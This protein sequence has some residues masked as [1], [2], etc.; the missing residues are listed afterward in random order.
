MTSLYDRL[1]ILTRK[2]I[3]Y[4]LL[5]FIPAILPP[6]TAKGLWYLL[7]VTNFSFYVSYALFDYKATYS[8]LMPAFHGLMLLA[9]LC[10]VI[11][12]KRVS[13]LF[14]IF[15]V[16][17]FAFSV[18]TQTMVHTDTYGLVILTEIFV[19]YSIVIALWIWEIIVQKNDLSFKDGMRPW[20]LLP[21]AVVAYWDPDQ[22]WNF[23]LVFFIKGF[24]PTAFCM[25]TPIYLTLLMFA[26]PNINL[27]LVRIHSYI[28]L[29]VGFIS[30]SISLI[31]A[32]SDGLYWILLHAPLIIV[33]FYT[34]RH[35]YRLRQERQPI[36]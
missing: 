5:V 11:F 14:S 8:Y 27:P 12:R 15:V 33:S 6:L 4:L 29:I 28:G 36:Q 19:W 13:R 30:L 22:A 25:L 1:E 23:S 34:F 20:W 2:R 35:S 31:Q 32:P 3:F 21:L 16:L 26:Y 17:N 10:V 9:L 18:F 7:D 24:S